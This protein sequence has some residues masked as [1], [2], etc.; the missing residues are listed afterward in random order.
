MRRERNFL[1][2]AKPEKPLLQDRGFDS[3]DQ[4]GKINIATAPD[5]V[6]SIVFPLIIVA[7]PRVFVV[8]PATG[9]AFW[10]FLGGAGYNLIRYNPAGFQSGDKN[11][12]FYNRAGRIVLI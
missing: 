3:I 8:Q 5:G 6:A 11:Q 9:P 12:R 10:S 2:V 7:C 4:T 1:A